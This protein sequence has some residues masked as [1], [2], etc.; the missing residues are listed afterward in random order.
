MV[1]L[2]SIEVGESR[3]RLEEL[4]PNGFWLTGLIA[5]PSVKFV[6]KFL[7]SQ[8]SQNSHNCQILKSTL[9]VELLT[10]WFETQSNATLSWECHSTPICVLSFAVRITFLN[11][12]RCCHIWVEVLLKYLP[13]GASSNCAQPSFAAIR[14]SLLLSIIVVDQLEAVRHSSISQCSLAVLAYNIAKPFKYCTLETATTGN[15]RRAKRLSN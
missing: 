6:A 12:L 8:S 4:T 13:Y 9:S 7:C 10:D 11:Q 5:F 1:I 14:F 3:S 2:A 15:T